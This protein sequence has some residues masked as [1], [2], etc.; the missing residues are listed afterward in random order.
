MKLHLKYLWIVLVACT[1]TACMNGGGD[2]AGKWQLRQYQYA[3]RYIREGGQ[4]ILII[5]KKEVFLPYVC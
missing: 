4:C 1:L 3:E 2:L 5:F